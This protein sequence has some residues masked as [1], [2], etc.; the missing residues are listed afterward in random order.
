VVLRHLR[1][2]TTFYR[3]GHHLSIAGRA[4]MKRRLER[5]GVKDVKVK[6]IPVT[7][8]GVLYG[9]LMLRIPHCPD[10]RLIDGGNVASP[11]HRPHFT[12][13]KH[14]FYSGTY[15]CQRLSKP[16]DL[17]RPEGLGKFKISVYSSDS[18]YGPLFVSQELC[19]TKLI[20]LF[21][22]AQ[23]LSWRSNVR[24]VSSGCQ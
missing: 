24:S 19:F 3:T 2:I 5:H 18:G 17:V 20:S 15:F 10:N 7:G 6:A 14:Y 16:Q 8:R 23:P 13:Q 21:N 12:P 1:I 9:C 4:V 22:A 11:M